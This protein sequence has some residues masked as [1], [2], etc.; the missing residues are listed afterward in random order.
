MIC[1]NLF[2]IIFF[3]SDVDQ[4]GEDR[5]VTN[6]WY[7]LAAGMVT[8]MEVHG[9][10]SVILIGVEYYVIKVIIISDYNLFIYNFDKIDLK[11]IY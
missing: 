10:A 1:L 11:P 9:N 3:F 4:A 7:I 6:A 2:N 5:Y 8:V